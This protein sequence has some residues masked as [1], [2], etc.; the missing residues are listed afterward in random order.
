MQKCGIFLK[1][2]FVSDACNAGCDASVNR[3][4]CA[5][6][7]GIDRTWSRYT[8]DMGPMWQ[9]QFGAGM[10]LIDDFAHPEHAGKAL[11][12]AVWAVTLGPSYH[13]SQ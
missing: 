10:V 13:Y 8:A 9:A 12:L 11:R 2:G 6:C 4:F 7:T 3:R 5:L 1:K